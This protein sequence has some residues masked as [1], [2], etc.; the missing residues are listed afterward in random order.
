M[1]TRL[2]GDYDVI[3]VLRNGDVV[4]SGNHKEL[5]KKGGFYADLYNSQFSLAGCD[6]EEV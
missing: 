2:Q 4:E 1:H 5:I 3:L 6:P